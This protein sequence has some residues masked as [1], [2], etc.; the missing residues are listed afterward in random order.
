MEIE[1][2]YMPMDEFSKVNLISSI[3]FF[4]INAWE[5][6]EVWLVASTITC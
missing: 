5:N 3:D 4:S 1:F 2:L 6:D